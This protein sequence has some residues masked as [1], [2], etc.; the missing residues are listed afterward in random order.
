MRNN[1]E[2]RI[3]FG[4]VKYYS[5]RRVHEIE[6]EIAVREGGY[7]AICGGIWN[8]RKTDYEFCGQC[9]DELKDWVEERKSDFETIY[10]IWKQWHLSPIE[11]VPGEVIKT[12]EGI[13]GG[14]LL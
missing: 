10:G 2:Y 12:L 7:L 3:S 9:L 8:G 11:R 14:R 4:K 13:C 6:V 1:M 5:K